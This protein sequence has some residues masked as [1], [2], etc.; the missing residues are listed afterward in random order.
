MRCVP[1]EKVWEQPYSV[2]C[3]LHKL[4]ASVKDSTNVLDD[5][6]SSGQRR[7]S[8]VAASKQQGGAALALGTRAAFNVL[9]PMLSLPTRSRLRGRAC[10]IIRLQVVLP[11]ISA[12]ALDRMHPPFP[13][14][15]STTAVPSLRDSST[16]LVHTRS[17]RT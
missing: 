4:V 6:G 8:A 2:A 11:D 1:R 10:P 7:C 13:M 12:V 3:V 14:Q 15:P 16:L 17:I 5:E 9:L